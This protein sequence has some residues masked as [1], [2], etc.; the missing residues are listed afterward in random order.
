MVRNND[1]ELNK[2]TLVAWVDKALDVALSKRNIKS[3]FQVTRIWPFNPKVTDGRIKPNEFYSVDHDDT[4]NEDNV[5]NFN[6]A[7]NDIKG[8][9]E[10]ATIIKLINIATTI[11]EL[12][13]TKADVDYNNN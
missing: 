9:G 11:D 10:Y 13:T 8:L 5:K 1:N 3:E 6:E 12:A 7:M 4:S 2:V